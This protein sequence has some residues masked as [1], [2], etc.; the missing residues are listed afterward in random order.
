MRKLV[1]AV[2]VIAF[3]WSSG[4]SALPANNP[5]TAGLIAA[6]EFTGNSDDVSGNGNDGVV[7][8]ATLG[9]DRFGNANSAYDFDGVDDFIEVADSP[10]LSLSGQVTVVGWVLTDSGSNNTIISKGLGDA[11]EE[12]L[13]TRLGYQSSESAGV[14]THLGTST[15]WRVIDGGTVALGEWHQVAMTYNGSLLKTYID[16]SEDLSVGWSGTLRDNAIPLK[17]GRRGLNT[18]NTGMNFGAPSYWDGQI[19]DVYIY[20]RALSAAEVSTLYA[21]VP[22][23]S[24]ALLLGIGL[25]GLAARRRV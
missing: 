20:N 11:D 19:D 13:L 14:R 1:L 16:G 18:W 12:Y 10:S 15:G 7:I 17:I 8:G 5:I 24:T 23:P 25:V 22:E 2:V 6:Y 3:G 4:A 21:V 9:S